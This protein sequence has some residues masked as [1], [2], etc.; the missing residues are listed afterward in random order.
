MAEQPVVGHDLELTS[1]NCPFHFSRGPGKYRNRIGAT[2]IEEKFGRLIRRPPT[3]A[4]LSGLG[5]SPGIARE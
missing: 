3:S 4:A 2:T 5:D 1:H